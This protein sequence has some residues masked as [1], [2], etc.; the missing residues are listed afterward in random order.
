MTPSQLWAIILKIADK[1][2]SFPLNQSILEFELFKVPYQKI[3]T[4]RDL[5][6]SVGLVLERR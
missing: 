1:R 3:A 4:L 6:L 2:F 5:C